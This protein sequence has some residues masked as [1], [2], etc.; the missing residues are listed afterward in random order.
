MEH[1]GSEETV[2]LSLE[3]HGSETGSSVAG[4]DTEEIVT[5]LETVIVTV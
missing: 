3:G 1:R 2:Y 4:E 5:D